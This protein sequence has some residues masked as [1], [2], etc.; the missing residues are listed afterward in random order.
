MF[1]SLSSPNPSYHFSR[2]K[3]FEPE[4]RRIPSLSSNPGDISQ[5]ERQ[6]K[7]FLDLRKYCWRQCSEPPLQSDDRRRAKSLHVR[8]RVAI[9]ERE[10]RQGYLVRAEPVL[11][12]QRHIEDKRPRRVGIMT[13]DDHHRP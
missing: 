8:N 10:A 5:I 9:Q 11:S 13:R 1:E 3:R 7:G 6:C 12:S 4:L 2:E